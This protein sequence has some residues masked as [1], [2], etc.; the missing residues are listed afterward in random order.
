MNASLPGFGDSETWGPCVDPRD[1]RY[2]E[3]PVSEKVVEALQNRLAQ[4]RASLDDAENELFRRNMDGFWFA[5]EDAYC[6][7]ETTVK[8]QA[9]A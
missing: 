7:L 9:V 1:P 3:P 5:L 8:Q 2:E 6:T 4:I